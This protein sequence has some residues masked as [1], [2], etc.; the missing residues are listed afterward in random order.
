LDNLYKF[1]ELIKEKKLDLFIAP[2]YYVSPFTAI[3]TIKF[4]HDLWPL[5]HPEWIPTTKEF[6]WR[7]GKNSLYDSLNFLEKFKSSKKGKLTISENRYFSQYFEGNRQN[8]IALYYSIMFLIAFQES[9]IIVS[10]SNNTRNEIEE[11]FPEYVHKVRIIPNTINRIF[12]QGNKEK[13]NTILHVANWEP[14]KNIEILLEAFQFLRDKNIKYEL[15]LAGGSTYSEYTKKIKNLI[16]KHPYSSFISYLGFVSD[17]QLVNL[18]RQAKVFVYPSLYEGFGIPILEAMAC[19]TPVVCSNTTALP[20]IYSDTALF[21]EMDKPLSLSNQLLRII[22]DNSLCE[23][24]IA[25][26]LKKVKNFTNGSVLEKF[27]SLIDSL[28]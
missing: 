2:Q 22:T 17:E 11:I 8:K 27:S 20:E 7:F 21:F 28:V 19:G 6:S 14:R 3:P 16:Q 1:P 5:I 10:P 18:Y 25:K 23:K 4:I 9:Q 15:I 24:L 13:R 26:G 12:C